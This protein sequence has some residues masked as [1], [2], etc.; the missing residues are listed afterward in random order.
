M[1]ISE[2]YEKLSQAEINSAH[3]I[4]RGSSRH[5]WVNYLSL[6]RR[7]RHNRIASLC[8]AAFE[9][10]GKFNHREV[11]RSVGETKRMIKKFEETIK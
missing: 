8:H 3:L 7:A 4:Q 11:L 5:A 9:R 10:N 1:K 2:E 6:I